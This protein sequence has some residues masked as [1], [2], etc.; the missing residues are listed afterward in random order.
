[1]IELE[2]LI[3][4][5][6]ISKTRKLDEEFVRKY[7]QFIHFDKLCENRHFQFSLDLIQDYEKKMNFGS[8][9]IYH[10]LKD[11]PALSRL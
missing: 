4:W 6:N 7:D 9:I 1:M 10:K 3:D 5:E 2:T 8:L 11:T